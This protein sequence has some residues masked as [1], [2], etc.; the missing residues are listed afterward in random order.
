[1]ASFIVV[2]LLVM[3]R[4]DAGVVKIEMISDEKTCDCHA[5][6]VFRVAVCEVLRL[7]SGW[8]VKV[9]QKPL[10]CSLAYVQELVKEA[11]EETQFWYSAF[12]SR[13]C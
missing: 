9:R 5:V 2:E 12:P 1:M 7:S 11:I 4:R 3:P 13:S 6:D 8:L 10:R